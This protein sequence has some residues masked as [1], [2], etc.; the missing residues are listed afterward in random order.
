MELRNTGSTHTGVPKRIRA[1]EY[2]TSSSC[3]QH[4]SQPLPTPATGAKRSMDS[5]PAPDAGPTTDAKPTADSRPATTRPRPV[6]NVNPILQQHLDREGENEL[7]SKP[8]VEEKPPSTQAPA[9]PSAP[10]PPPLSGQPK[11]LKRRLLEN[12]EAEGA[13]RNQPLVEPLYGR[14]CGSLP[15]GNREVAK[16]ETLK[17]VGVESKMDCATK[18]V[19][20]KVDSSKF[21]I[22][23]DLKEEVQV[24]A[25]LPEA[26]AN[27]L[28]EDSVLRRKD[29]DTNLSLGGG[30]L[31]FSHPTAEVLPVNVKEAESPDVSEVPRRIIL[32]SERPLKRRRKQTS[33]WDYCKK[34]QG[35][36]SAQERSSADAPKPAERLSLRR[37][38]ERNMS[39]LMQS[40]QP[41]RQLRKLRSRLDGLL[42]SR[43]TVRDRLRRHVSINTRNKPRKASSRKIPI[44]NRAEGSEVGDKSALAVQER[45]QD[46]GLR[47]HVTVTDIRSSPACTSTCRTSV[48]LPPDKVATK[49]H[50]CRMCSDSEIALPYRNKE[51][52]GGS[53]TNPFSSLISGVPPTALGVRL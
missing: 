21:Q 19:V 15:I 32:A 27:R 18:D 22:D 40:R 20:N 48:K 28:I 35:R 4:Y 31:T 3:L 53:G 47:L 8:L 12:F 39:Q 42:T 26:A 33:G 44:K 16:C 29:A 38:L 25:S 30:S 37:G 13:A 10:P 49:D 5:R 51:E 45:V 14:T 7:K 43:R 2:T 41:R 24:E 23:C 9:S 34:K 6:A 52:L 11:S 46:V 36:K 50:S 17:P 1:F